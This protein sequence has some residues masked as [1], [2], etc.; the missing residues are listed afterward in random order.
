MGSF[1]KLLFTVDSH[2]GGQP[3]RSIVGGL[4]R[5]RGANM[6]EKMLYMKEHYDYIRTMLTSEP[7][8]TNITSVAVL[9]E[10]TVAEA[11]IGAFY[12]EAH[13][14]M[15][16]CGHDTIGL[17][18]MLVETGMVEVTEPFTYITIETPAGLV[19]LRVTV[20]NGR[21]RT[22]TFK[23][24]ECF[25]FDTGMEVE[26]QGKKITFDV[27]YGGNFYA[28]IDVASVGLTVSPA[29]YKQLIKAGTELIGIINAK[30]NITH[31]EKDYLHGVTHVQ[32]TEPALLDHET[33]KSKNAVVFLPGDLDRCKALSV[34]CQQ[35]QRK[36]RRVWGI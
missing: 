27:A 21:A 5:L 29:D 30:Y 36:I 32:F 25:T 31:P 28:I 14:Y 26:Y 11:D 13:G 4:P 35:K 2:T 17:G 1:K 8:G 34:E 19:K 18:T 16:M 22:V 10:P 15:P 9:T 20:E 23:N 12:F 33:L 7:R 24:A 6:S 3:T